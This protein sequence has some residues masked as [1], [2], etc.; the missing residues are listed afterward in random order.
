MWRKPR[1]SRRR[2]NRQTPTEAESLRRY[3][4][5]LFSPSARQAR[6]RLE[7]GGRLLAGGWRSSAGI[8][9]NDCQRQSLAEAQRAR[10]LA[11]INQA[12]RTH[13]IHVAAIRREIEICLEEL[14]LGIVKLELNCPSH[15]HQLSTDRRRVSLEKNSRKLHRQRR[16]AAPPTSAHVRF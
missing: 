14:S 6:S 13:P 16:A 3:V 7:E 4:R 8:L 15:L 5:V 10:F 11:E 9:R 1:Q 2:A 12:C